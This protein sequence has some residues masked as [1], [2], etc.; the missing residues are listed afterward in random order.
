MEIKIHRKGFKQGVGNV[1][2]IKYKILSCNLNCE[3][4]HFKSFSNF[5]GF[6]GLNIKKFNI[7]SGKIFPPSINHFLG[8]ASCLKNFVLDRFSG[9]YVFFLHKQTTPEAEHPDKQSTYLDNVYLKQQQQ[10]RRF[11]SFSFLFQFNKSKLLQ[12]TVFKYWKLHHN[13]FDFL[14]YDTYGHWIN[15]ILRFLKEATYLVSSM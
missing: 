2:L 5:R 7:F 4:R 9:F 10:I 1:H 15:F 11:I 13:R 8:H 3:S 12:N 6:F 14:V